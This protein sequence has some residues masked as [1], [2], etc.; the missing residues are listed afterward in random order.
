MSKK[1]IKSLLVEYYANYKCNAFP[2][3]TPER[4]KICEWLDCNYS[5][6]GQSSINDIVYH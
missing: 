1:I 5:K 6:I 3:L 4:K 2:D